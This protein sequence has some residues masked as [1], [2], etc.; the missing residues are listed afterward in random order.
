MESLFFCSFIMCNRVAI[1]VPTR[2]AWVGSQPSPPVFDLGAKTQNQLLVKTHVNASLGSV[3]GF[4][5]WPPTLSVPRAGQGAQSEHVV[6]DRVHHL[7]DDVGIH[8]AKLPGVDGRKD[9]EG[10]SC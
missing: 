7:L 6:E 10:Y 9:G 1:D 2:S 4:F 5:S 3:R 8:T